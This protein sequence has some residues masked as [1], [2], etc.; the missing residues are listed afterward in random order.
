MRLRR[1][2]AL[3]TPTGGQ[4]KV[5]FTGAVPAALFGAKVCGIP[6]TAARALERRCASAAAI[7]GSGADP[8]LAWAAQGGAARLPR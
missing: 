5:Y 6:P 3:R 4:R 2:W 8:A 7:G 1:S